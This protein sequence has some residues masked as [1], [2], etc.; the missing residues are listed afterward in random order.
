MASTK[1]DNKVP[2]TVLTGFLGSGMSF[3]LS[4]LLSAL[5]MKDSINSIELFFELETV[6]ET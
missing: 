3:I 4:S 1:Q 5:K 6:D 2:V